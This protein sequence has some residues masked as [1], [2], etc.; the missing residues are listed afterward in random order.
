MP[1]QVWLLSCTWA[2]WRKGGFLH[3]EE[4]VGTKRKEG[5]IKGDFYTCW[6]GRAPFLFLF[7]FVLPEAKRFWTLKSCENNEK[8]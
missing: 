2:A 1:G 8:F 4:D 5:E 7:C 6:L 3:K